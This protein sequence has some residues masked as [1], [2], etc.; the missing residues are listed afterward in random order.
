M[1]PRSLAP[2]LLVTLTLAACASGRARRDD[3]GDSAT[4]E[5]R[6]SYPGP[7][8][9]YAIRDN[10][11]VQRIGNANTSAAQRFTLGPSLIG[12]VSTLRIVAVPLAENGR[13]STGT[14]TV[15]PGD[16]V[17]FNIAVNLNASSVFVR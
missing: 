6:N 16:V 4:L 13:A 3:G 9:L 14:I 8:T 1:R 7:I 12:G 10:G 11:F 2:T 17:Q 15:R 5:V